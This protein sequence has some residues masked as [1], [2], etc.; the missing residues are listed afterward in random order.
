MS[1][2]KEL[3]KLTYFESD[4]LIRSL[5]VKHIH[6]YIK[7]VSNDIIIKTPQ[8]NKKS[9]LKLLSSFMNDG[10][11]AAKNK[12]VL[13]LSSGIKQGMFALFFFGFFFLIRPVIPRKI[14]YPPPQ[15][16]I[17]FRCFSKFIACVIE[18]SVISM[19]TISPNLIYILVVIAFFAPYTRLSDMINATPGPID[20]VCDK[21]IMVNVTNVV[22]SIGLYH[23]RG[24]LR[25]DILHRYD[26]IR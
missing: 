9:V 2:N 12:K 1:I 18:N 21:V 16:F 24:N 6:I 20:T 11:N 23:A 10:I 19:T 14:R 8:S 7:S 13:G 15:I 25:I 4:V 26:C 17:A 3:I 22:K 5:R